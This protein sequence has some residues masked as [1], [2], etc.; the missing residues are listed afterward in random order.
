MHAPLLL[1]DHWHLFWCVQARTLH[2]L[3]HDDAGPPF[4]LA[5]S[6]AELQRVEHPA[7]AA[8]AAE[9]AKAPKT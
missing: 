5:L 9:Q 8:L 3:G 2:L 1:V 7:A 6:A 4:V